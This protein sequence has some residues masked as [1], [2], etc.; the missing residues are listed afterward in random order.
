MLP[1]LHITQLVAQHSGFSYFEIRRISVR[2]SIYPIV[3]YSLFYQVEQLHSK[4]FVQD[5]ALV[6]FR[7][8]HPCWHM[9]RGYHSPS[10]KMVQYLPL[11][12]IYPPC[13]LVDLIS[14]KS[15]F[16]ETLN[17]DRMRIEWSWFNCYLLFNRLISLSKSESQ[18][19]SCS[20]LNFSNSVSAICLASSV[21][22]PPA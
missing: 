4:S 18:F 1:I 15:C 14:D 7:I 20:F 17:A 3:G 19:L 9:V 21:D 6:L 16:R 8:I 2:V 22:I 13:V 5:T 10:L 11:T 12:P